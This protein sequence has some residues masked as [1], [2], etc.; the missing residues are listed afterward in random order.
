MEVVGR[1]ERLA[2]DARSDQLTVALDELSIRLF[3][4]QHLRESRDNEWIHD[5]QKYGCDERHQCSD[6]E[7]ASDVH[8]SLIAVMMMSM[9]LMPMNGT[10]TPPTP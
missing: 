1:G 5:T 8:A 6:D 2:D 4:K 3:G 7:I 9:I 10:I